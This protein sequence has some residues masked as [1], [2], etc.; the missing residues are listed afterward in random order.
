MSVTVAKFLDVANGVQPN[1]FTVG[2]RYSV[3]SIS[4]LDETYKHLVSA[5]SR[6]C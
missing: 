4:D 6:R 5:W 3:D 1:Q 2:D